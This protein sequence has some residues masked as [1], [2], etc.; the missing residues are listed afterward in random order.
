MRKLLP[1]AAALAIATSGAAYANPLKIDLKNNQNVTKVGVKAPGT[2][3]VKI[4]DNPANTKVK[5]QVPGT[6][7]V[8]L[9]VPSL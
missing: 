6:G 1:V 5:V 4:M 9:K 2:G 3:S 7:K 8:Q